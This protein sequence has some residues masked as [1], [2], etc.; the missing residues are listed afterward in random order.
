GADAPLERRDRARARRP[1]RRARR[2]GATP[3]VKITVLCADLADNGAGRAFLL[4]RL[5]APLGRVELIGPSTGAG[6]WAPIAAPDLPCRIVPRPKLPRFAR[7]LADL[8]RMADGDL[9]CASKPRLGSA[10][11]GYLE[12]ARSRRPLL[13]DIDDWEIGFFLRGG[14]W[15]TIG[16]S[17][18]LRN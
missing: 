14:V 10:G 3:V 17:L 16:R 9:L 11:V 5:L 12:R 1:L 6:L 2:R 15:G 7:S 13:L 18:N 4:A 8:C